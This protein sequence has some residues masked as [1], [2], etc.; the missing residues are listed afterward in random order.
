MKQLDIFGNKSD[1]IDNKYTKK[2]KA[3]I[4]EPKNRKPHILELYDYTKTNR[5]I[6][7]IKN[8]GISNEEKRFLIEAA[9]RHTVFNYSKIADYYAHSSKEMQKL[10][11]NSALVILDFEKSIELGYTKLSDNLLQTFL[12]EPTN[13]K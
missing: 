12:N 1:D 11:E 7:Q 3:P 8:S 10:M 6:N 4:Y 13:E 2:I 9:K 5:L